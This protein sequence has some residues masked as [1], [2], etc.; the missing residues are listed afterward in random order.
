[1]APLL[2][3]GLVGVTHRSVARKSRRDNK[4]RAGAQQ[5]DAGLIA[6]LHAPAREER[7]AAMQVRKLSS[8]AEVQIAARRTELIVERVGCRIMLLADVAMLALEEFA[9]VKISI[10]FLP[11]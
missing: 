2:E 4:V 8:L 5:F 9:R 6:D 10:R 1:M 3:I 7:N 11:R